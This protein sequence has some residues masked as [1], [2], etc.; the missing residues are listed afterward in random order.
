MC[1]IAG[2]LN[3]R[4]GE[5]VA[6]ESIRR[7]CR[8][9]THRGPDDEGIFLDR[10]FG[11][12]MRRLS[13]IDLFTG[14]QP[15]GNEDGSVWTVFNGEIYNFLDLKAD[16]E[17]KGHRFV[18]NTDTEVIVHLYEAYGEDFPKRLAGMFAIALWDKKKRKL[19]LARDRLGIKPLFYSVDLGR[20]L[21]GSEL[22]A[23][24]KEDERTDIDL[25]ALHDYLSLNYVPGPR[26]ILQKIKKLDPGHILVCS[27]GIV[28]AKPYWTLDWPADGAYPARSEESYCE[29]LRELLKEVLKQHLIS[30]VPLGVFLSGGVDSSALVALMSEVSAQTIRT[31]SIGFEEGSYDELSYARLVAKKFNTRHSELIVRPDA[32]DLL[33]KMIRHFDEPFGDS[34]AIPVY[35]VS[36]LARNQVKVALS[37][38]G[39]DEVFAGYETYTACRVAQLYQRLPDF[40]AGRIIPAV[41]R[42][43]PVSHRKVS[44]D[45]KAK[46][47]VQGA[48]LP[49]LE[50]HYWWKVLFTEDAKSALYADGMDGFDD[51]LRLYRE[52][53][54]GC[55]A[56]D[57]ISKLQ[58]VDL[59]LY[60]PDDILVKAD[61]MSM[62]ASLELRVPFLDHRVVEFSI[63]LPP[64]L[65]L[66]RLTK[67][68]IL[69]RA[70]SQL[71]PAKILRGKKRGFNVP[72]PIWLRRELRPMVQEVLGAKQL[73]ETGIFNPE[74]ISAMMRDHWM[75]R[76]D[77]SRNL[78]ALLVFMLWHR[79]FARHPADASR[80]SRSNCAEAEG[81]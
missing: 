35:C 18:T 65:R 34:S 49:P 42:R 61:R 21:F 1:G 33:P 15:I 19:V 64:A 31:F 32:V 37:G 50:A 25:Q 56:P 47:F 22:K 74:P 72:I 40:L 43:L 80:V 5:P 24:L 58:H 54:E 70:L 7:M 68:Y 36:K 8:V 4:S 13:V 66:H 12:G 53:H 69:R 62:A 60:L 39:G 57:V 26:T 52:A 2:K 46:R 44:F 17:A 41:V 14:H 77:Y 55:A 9:L 63:S 38:E 81:N 10:N 71:L 76:A 67:K 11:M 59:K 6:E 79:E 51:P 28:T 3:F 29:E 45:Y 48:L 23:I 30:D 27:R 73:R 20:V 78:W 16:L 75:K